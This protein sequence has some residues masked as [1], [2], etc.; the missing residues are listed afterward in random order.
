MEKNLYSVF[1]RKAHVF[2]NPF[3]SI[4]DATAERVFISACRDDG[5]DIGMFPSDY[6]LYFVGTFD[7]ETGKLDPMPIP[8]NVCDGRAVINREE[9]E[10][11]TS[12][13][14]FEERN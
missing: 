4:N 2:A 5:N 11:P 10:Y 7:D 3:Y 13:K 8:R 12:L 6:A 9:G 14:I 1:D